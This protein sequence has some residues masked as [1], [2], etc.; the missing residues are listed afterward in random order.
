MQRGKAS[1][2]GRP[3]YAA[4][5]QRFI[6]ALVYKDLQIRR[7]PTT[8]AAVRRVVTAARFS[9]PSVRLALSSSV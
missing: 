7:I 1:F 5:V 3:D 6:S 4:Q 9:Q 2:N 8:A